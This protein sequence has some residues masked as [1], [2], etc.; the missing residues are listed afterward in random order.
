[1]SPTIGTRIVLLNIIQYFPICIDAS[2]MH[3]PN[4]IHKI[5]RSCTRCRCSFIT[6]D[7]FAF[8]PFAFSQKFSPP[9]QTISPKTSTS[10]MA[11]LTRRTYTSKTP[12]RKG[13]CFPIQM[14]IYKI[15]CIV[16]NI[17][18]IHISFVGQ[19]ETISHIQ[20][21]I[22]YQTDRSRSRISREIA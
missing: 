13:E 2:K 22:S 6:R 10:K 19:T 8:N 21:S 17:V 15:P 20:F 7:F 1:M 16:C 11:T 3:T 14:Y 9:I 5:I 4:Y 12:H 18:A